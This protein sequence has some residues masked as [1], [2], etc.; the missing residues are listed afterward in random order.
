VGA[1]V[2]CSTVGNPRRIPSDAVVVRQGDSTD[3]LFLVTSGAI[4]LSCVTLEGR[5]I[6]VGVLGRGEVFGE[7]ALL[8][9]PSPV[10]ARAIGQ[11]DV[12]SLSISQLRD[13]LRHHPDTAE[14]LLRLV[15]ARLHR[16]GRALEDSL[17]GAVSARLSGRLSELAETHGA[18]TPE[19]VRIGVP[20]TRE[21]LARMVGS[22]RE[23]ISRTMGG[24]EGRGLV[25]TKGRTVVI[26]DPSALRAAP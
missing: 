2:R 9:R 16:T 1:L 24:L 17:T 15:A 18:D 13:V 19:G 12:L 6:V 4:R 11:T 10:E 26:P 20:L 25:R 23:S 7:C 5:E 14:E 21:E 22:T 3:S 8:G